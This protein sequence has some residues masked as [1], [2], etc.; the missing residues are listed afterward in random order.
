VP[1]GVSHDVETGAADGEGPELSRAGYVVR[2]D[3]FEGPFDLLLR[4]IAQRKLDLYAVDLAEMTADFLAHLRLDDPDDP[5]G[6]GGLDLETATHFLVVAATLIE[7]KAARLLPDRSDTDSDEDLLGEARDLL[8]ARLLEYRAFREASERLSSLLDTE[9]GHH[10]RRAGLDPRFRNVLPPLELEI[11]PRALGRLASRALAP[12]PAVATRH[13]RQATMSVRDAAAR[14]LARLERPGREV[15]Y[16][17][18]AGRLGVPERVAHFLALLELYKVGLVDLS[19]D[20]GFG[21]LVVSRRPGEPDL[22]VVD[23]IGADGEA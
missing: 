9:A 7:L 14:L 13:I 11:D 8:Y 4:L 18:V 16:R 21:D 2:L 20:E 1:A 3:V 19:Q 12:A 23:R 17:E 6:L 5:A 22:S 15:S 10:P